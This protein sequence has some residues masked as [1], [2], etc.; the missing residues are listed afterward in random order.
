MSGETRA[1]GEDGAPDRPI[2]CMALDCRDLFMDWERQ[3]EVAR[4][5]EDA[6]FIAEYYD[7]FE[8]WAGYLGVFGSHVSSLDYRLRRH[9]S[10][11]DLVMRSLDILRNGLFVAS[12]RRPTFS[13]PDFV[14]DDDVW[15]P[16]SSPRELLTTIQDAVEELDELGLWIRSSSRSSGTARARAFAETHG[17]DLD[18]FEYRANSAVEMLYPNSARSLRQQLAASMADRYARVQYEECRVKRKEIPASTTLA[19]V[20]D[21]SFTRL[22]E[23]QPPDV[24]PQVTPVNQ[25]ERTRLVQFELPEITASSLVTDP[26][27]RRVGPAS[28]PG[29]QNPPTE[30]VHG[31]VQAHPPLP[32]FE[33]NRDYAT[34]EWCFRILDKSMFENCTRWSKGGKNH[35]RQDL[36]PYICLSESCAQTFG[37]LRKWSQHMAMSHSSDWPWMIHNST[38]WICKAGH[39]YDTQYIFSTKAEIRN[40]AMLHHLTFD[41]EKVEIVLRDSEEDTSSAR[42]CPLCTY[43]VP[44]AQESKGYMARHVA[45]HL[46]GLMLLTLRLMSAMPGTFG[47]EEDERSVFSDHSERDACASDGTLLSDHGS[48]LQFDDPLPNSSVSP[49]RSAIGD[50]WNDMDIPAPANLDVND[51]RAIDEMLRVQTMRTGLAPDPAGRGT[52]TGD[53]F[54][55]F[56][57]NPDFVGREAIIDEL[58]QMVFTPKQS[59]QVAIFGLGGVGMTQVALELVYRNRLREPQR[60]VF[61]V[62]ALSLDMFRHACE[63]ITKMRAPEFTGDR[64]PIK[65]L[66][67]YLSSGRV[68]KWLL[69]IDGIDLPSAVFG[70]AYDTAYKGISHY[71]PSHHQGKTLF[72]TRNSQLATSLAGSHAIELQTMSA[73]EAESLLERSLL[74]PLP[75]RLRERPDASDKDKGELLE[76][77]ELHP[78]AIRQAAAFINTNREPIADYMMR[79]NLIGPTSA[80]TQELPD[81]TRYMGSKNGMVSTW[82]PIFEHLRVACPTAGNLLFLFSQI[83]PEAI[84]GGLIFNFRRES[85][86]EDDTTL[87]VGLLQSYG[88]LSQRLADATFKLHKLVYHATR[89]WIMEDGKRRMSFRRQA[90]SYMNTFMATGAEESRPWPKYLPHV[91]SLLNGEHDVSEIF[92][93]KYALCLQV[94]RYLFAQGRKDDGIYWVSRAWEWQSIYL[95]PANLT[96]LSTQEEVRQAYESVGRLSDAVRL[97]PSESSKLPSR[98]HGGPACT[99]WFRD[100]GEL[101]FILRR[102]S[103]EQLIKF[104]IFDTGLIE[105]YEKPNLSPAGYHDFVDPTR[106]S[107]TDSTGHGS[108]MFKT[109][110]RIYSRAQFFV[111]RVSETNNPGPDTADLIVK[112]E[113][114]WSVYDNSLL[115]YMFRPSNTQSMYGMSI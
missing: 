23:N 74:H 60:S 57:R 31:L 101:T 65:T 42:V 54:V 32:V 25:P 113:S 86:T 94:G 3:P 90:I 38:V 100:L 89:Y 19:P 34:C 12:I 8:A 77:L 56:P 93:E 4:D 73:T 55:P 13:Q 83:Q 109:L 67:D 85:D 69:V 97:W 44:E 62:P 7:R 87:A 79:I 51:T 17:L 40:H 18:G 22:L 108:N 48:D 106:A 41:A 33:D 39:E 96:L 58:E 104:A 103:N 105:K 66:R 26:R 6:R 2:R 72:T 112:V 80:A 61:W 76:R 9:A 82:Q 78:L 1:V 92:E 30:S 102:R 71:F 10:V 35:Y 5:S 110:R 59:S 49:A 50:N 88:F 14:D 95:D 98:D 115:T 37:S 75:Q 27:D 45:A 63:E 107:F 29:S 84:P 99:A 52:N 21:V 81:V 91:T 11:Q 47:S 53:W 16:W 20:N 24:L 43:L 46:E 36:Q 28:E 70:S 15:Y 68:G 111:G 114:I 64:D